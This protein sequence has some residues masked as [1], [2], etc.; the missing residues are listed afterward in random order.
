MTRPE[1]ELVRSGAVERHPHLAAPR[2][3]G[4]LRVDCHL[5]TMWSGDSTT[6][7]DELAERRSLR[8]GLDVVCITDH[9]TIAGALALPRRPRLQ[10]RG[11]PGATNAFR[12]ADRA[13]P[14]QADPAGTADRPA[15]RRLQSGTKAASSTCP[16]LSTRC[17][18]ARRGGASRTSPATGLIDAIEV[19]N[20]KTSLEHLNEEAAR[21]ATRLGL[22]AGAGSDAHVPEAVGSAYVEM[23]D[24][25]DGPSFLQLT[26]R[27]SGHRSPLRRAL[28]P[29]GHE[30]CPRRPLRYRRST[31]RHGWVEAQEAAAALDLLGLSARDGAAAGVV[32]GA[33]RCVRL[34]AV[35]LSAAA[36]L[37]LPPDAAAAVSDPPPGLCSRRSWR[38]RARA[39]VVLVEAASLEHDPDAPEHLPGR[40][41]SWGTR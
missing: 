28:R 31:R 35:V 26:S 36:G 12:R 20:G 30:S 41:R 33:A 19:R 1:P 21:A 38:N 40:L 9:S 23:D 17:G 14:L 10:G 27:R 11:R 3:P 13:V 32:A 37:E 15:T 4:R 39:A 16:T 18:T 24:F 6:T 7:P 2:P 25:S 22:P 29:S 8:A 34:A 5:H